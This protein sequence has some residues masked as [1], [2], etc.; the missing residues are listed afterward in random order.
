MQARFDSSQRRVSHGG[1]LREVEIGEIA[2]REDAEL[3]CW[4]RREGA[5]Q[6]LTPLALERLRE[7][8]TRAHISLQSKLVEWFSDHNVTPRILPAAIGDD[9]EQPG[10]KRTI[11]LKRWQSAPD[12]QP[13]LLRDLL[14]GGRIAEQCP[15][16]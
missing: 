2:Q 8:I 6:F 9:G 1:N 10:A 12:I 13:R 15:G 14:C 16:S 3:F 5:R 4:Q 11:C 7:P